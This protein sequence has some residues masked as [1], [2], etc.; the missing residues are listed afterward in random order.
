MRTKP[1]TGL[2]YLKWFWWYHRTNKFQPYVYHKIALN[3]KSYKPIF[4]QDAFDRAKTIL[5]REF[6][7]Y[8]DLY[9][10]FLTDIPDTYREIVS[11][12]S[13]YHQQDKNTH[14]LY[15]ETA[16]LEPNEFIIPLMRTFRNIK[17]YLHIPPCIKGRGPDSYPD[18]TVDSYEDYVS[19]QQ[20][21]YY[22]INS[23]ELSQTRQFYVKFQGVSYGSITV[24][25]QR[26]Q[27]N[28]ECLSTMYNEFESIQFNITSQCSGDPFAYC[29]PIT[30][31]VEMESSYVR[32][33]EDDCRYPDQVR[34]LV[35]MG[36]MSC[37]GGAGMGTSYL[38]SWLVVSLALIVVKYLSL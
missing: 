23:N 25:M 36:D 32:C 10:I 3:P 12:L 11:S 37:N 2:D 35:Q 31:R 14:F 21:N 18:T 9:F 5:Q 20:D 24:C 17:K 1:R 30:F 33:T 28:F 15:V 6:S 13:S 34:Y 19:R 22:Q 16:K 38:M 26:V 29:Q 27:D 4:L 7:K 8:H